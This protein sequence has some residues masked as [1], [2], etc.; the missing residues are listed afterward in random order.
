MTRTIEH[1]LL[2]KQDEFLRA[3][4]CRELL[5]SGAFSA[6][7]SRAL[8]YKLVARASVPG[9]REGLC[10]KH[11]VTAKATT[12]RTLLEP[13]GLMQPVLP[14]G[15]YSHNKSEKIIRIHGGGEI[16]Y[17]GLD[18]QEK[19][20]SYSLSGCAIDEAVEV[21][22]QDWTQ[23]LGRI[24]LGVGIPNQLYAAC[25]PGPPSHFLAERFGLAKGHN[26]KPGCRAIQTKSSDNTYLDAEYLE[27]LAQFSGVARKRYVEGLWVGSDGL[28]YD[29]W[30][31]SAFVRQRPRNQF[32][33]SLVA[34]DAGYTNPCVHLLLM[35]DSDGGLHVADEWVKTKQ[36]EPTVIEHA[37][38]WAGQYGVEVFVVDP[39]A[40]SLIA[41]MRANGLH[42][43][44]ANNEVF[45]GIQAVQARLTV[46]GNGQPRLTVDPRCENTIREFETY[47]WQTRRG[48]VRDVPVKA[49]DHCMDAIRYGIMEIDGVLGAPLT[50]DVDVAGRDIASPTD[51][52]LGDDDDDDEAWR[53]E[54]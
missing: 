42:V 53:E 6:G 31:R 17:F 54:W 32:V 16:V 33:R 45:S 11:L 29:R 14:L 21:S 9:A 18:D 8:C 20:G 48:E 35:Q 7:K 15:C 43:Q 47:E 10:R 25:N 34:V 13:D 51:S 26:A 27:S 41:G 44:A 12:L 50:L 19:I 22:P 5:F 52:F 3:D 40:A 37:Q 4:D 24:R 2:P 28:I 39:S 38:E 23:L 1:L 36:L 46:A 49:H 30:D